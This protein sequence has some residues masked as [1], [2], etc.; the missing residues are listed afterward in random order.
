MIITRENFNSK[1]NELAEF[2]ADKIGSPM[3]ILIH[4]LFFASIYCAPF[5]GY[6]WGETFDFLT[7]I[8]SIEAIYLA[9]FIQLIVTNQKKKEDNNNDKTGN[10]L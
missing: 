10:T 5:F 6:S 7:N 4:T 2:V 1:F 3:S 8:V 9:L